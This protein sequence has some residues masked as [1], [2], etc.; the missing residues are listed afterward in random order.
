MLRYYVGVLAVWWIV[1]HLA[2]LKEY[3]LEESLHMLPS[4]KAE[5]SLWM[6]LL[7]EAGDKLG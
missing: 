2:G 6:K 3:L 1:F 7:S 5:Q 4:I